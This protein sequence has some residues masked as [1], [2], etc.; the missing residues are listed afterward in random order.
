M[1]AAPRSGRILKERE[2]QFRPKTIQVPPNPSLE[3]SSRGQGEPSAMAASALGGGVEKHDHPD[4]RKQIHQEEHLQRAF[5]LGRSTSTD[6]WTSVSLIAQQE[7]LSPG[8]WKAIW[9]RSTEV[10]L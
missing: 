5:R 1:T 10:W 9:R 4:R 2:T 6:I 7:P 3:R 8:A